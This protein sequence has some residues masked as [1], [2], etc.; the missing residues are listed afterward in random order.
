[1]AR[2]GAFEVIFLRSEVV[3][4][5]QLRSPSSNRKPIPWKQSLITEQSKWGHRCLSGITGKVNFNYWYAFLY[6][7]NISLL[8]AFKLILWLFESKIDSTFAAMIT[9]KVK[10]ACSGCFLFLFLFVGRKHELV[11]VSNG[12][13]GRKL[14]CTLWVHRTRHK[15]I[16]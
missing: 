3:H 4:T 10:V 6:K 16:H 14:V 15:Y 12:L 1:M 5:T 8:F 2:S 7:Q 9:E 11:A 13:M